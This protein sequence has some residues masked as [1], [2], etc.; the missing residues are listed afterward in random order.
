MNGWHSMEFE[1]NLWYLQNIW[2]VC[3]L[4]Y[5]TSTWKRER[6]REREREKQQQ[7]F[8][9][10]KNLLPQLNYL[11]PCVMTVFTCFLILVKSWLVVL[12]L[13]Y[14]MVM[15]SKPWSCFTNSFHRYSKLWSRFTNSFHNFSKL[16]SCFTNSFHRYI[17]SWSCFINLFHLYSKLWSRFTNFIPSF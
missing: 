2:N 3:S 14:I 11:W 13:Y 15:Y 7:P 17:K 10:I 1:S 4:L 6:E 12:L 5:K 8:Y 16:W 9:T